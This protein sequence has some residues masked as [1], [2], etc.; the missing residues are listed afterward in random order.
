LKGYAKFITAN[1]MNKQETKQYI[2]ARI[3]KCNDEIDKLILAKKSFL[4]SKW[5]KERSVLVKR[6]KAI[7]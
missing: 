4:N 1:N 3:R 2:K 7:A 6:L 5:E